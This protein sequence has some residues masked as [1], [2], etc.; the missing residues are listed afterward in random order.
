[1]DSVTVQT[2][3]PVDV[4][5]EYVRGGFSGAEAVER[6]LAG[7]ETCRL[8]VEMLRALAAPIDSA[9]SD[10]ERARTY[11][12]IAAQ[13]EVRSGGTAGSTWLRATWRI[14]AAVALL[15]TSVGVLR[16]VQAGG[17]TDWDP[18]LAMEGWTQELADIELTDGEMRMA[19]GAGFF[20]D[21]AFDPWAGASV[22][23]GEFD[24]PWEER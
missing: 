23:P 14:A 6:H 22:D 8:E 15:L 1:M 4:L 20:D 9:L 19:L 3:H 7:C 16:V 17:A 21:P 12:A 24:I 11:R 5:P 13:R 10:L 2:D 18:D